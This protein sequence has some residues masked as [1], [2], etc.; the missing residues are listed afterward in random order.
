MNGAVPLL[1]QYIPSGHGQ[2][3]LYFHILLGSLSFHKSL[4][5]TKTFGNVQYCI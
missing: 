2:G 3:Q 5:M 1:P 4:I